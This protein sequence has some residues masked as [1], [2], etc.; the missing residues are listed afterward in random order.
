M[1]LPL[2]NIMKFGVQT[3]YRRTE[4]AV[5]PWTPDTEDAR[6]LIRLVDKTTILSLITRRNI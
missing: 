5:G 6:R 1:T 3:I 2:E 4:P